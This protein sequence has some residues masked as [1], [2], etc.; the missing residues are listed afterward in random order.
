MLQGLGTGYVSTTE[1]LAN[2]DLVKQ[3]QKIFDLVMPDW[4]YAQ[5]ELLSLINRNQ[6]DLIKA[7]AERLR[8]LGMPEDQI[9]RV[10][11]EKKVLRSISITAPTDSIIQDLAVRPGMAVEPGQALVTLYKP[12]SYWLNIWVAEEQAAKISLG[13]KVQVYFSSSFINTGKVT[14]I[15]PNLD[16]DTRRAQIRIELSDPQLKVGMSGLALIQL[17]TKEKVIAIPTEAIIHTGTMKIT[18]VAESEG[19]FYP[20]EIITGRQFNQHTEIIAGIDEGQDVVVSGQFLLDSEAQ[21]Q[22]IKPIPAIPSHTKE[23]EHHQDDKE[24][25]P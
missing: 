21:L 13:N 24:V 9:K 19:Q 8:V 15:L 22:N 14:E 18:M 5:Q 17:S 2:G 10:M 11:T 7:A 12:H 25:M 3:S 4:I 16:K 20:Q 6:T 1:K 23:H